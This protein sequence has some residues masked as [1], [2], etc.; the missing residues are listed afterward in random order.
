MIT[1]LCT[2]NPHPHEAESCKK[3]GFIEPSIQEALDEDDTPTVT[4]HPT[5]DIKE[6]KA[7]NKSTKKR[8]MTKKWKTIS[9]KKRRSKSNPTPTL[10]SKFTQANN[11]KSLFERSQYRGFQFSPLL[12]P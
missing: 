2:R 4:Q 9:M 8:I 12:S 1:I 3:D 6:V 7:T 5:L 11:K 10:T